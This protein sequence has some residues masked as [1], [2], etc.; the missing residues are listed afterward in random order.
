MVYQGCSS[1][2]VDLASQQRNSVSSKKEWGFEHQTS[3]PR[4]PQSNGLA[5]RAVQTAKGI[6]KKSERDGTDINKALLNM[7]NVPRNQELGS[8]AQRLFSRRTK[9]TL[10]VSAD[11]LKPEIINNVKEKLEALR[12]KQKTYADI[13]AAPA[14]EV[15]EGSKVRVFDSHR[16]WIPGTIVASTPH[17]RSFI[18]KTARGN[19]RRNTSFIR[20]T[21]ANLKDTKTVV[22]TVHQP[23]PTS[24]EERDSPA[25]NGEAD[26]QSTNGHSTTV[27]TGR[28]VKAP[29][30][31]N[32]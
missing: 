6:I 25:A 29:V 23:H 7:R 1:Q 10:P 27:T 31:L 3:S 5:E 16:K 17:P 15:K 21:K 18:V 8:P 4:Y 13:H 28:L 26:A 24:Q 9:T 19:L 30:R 12:K 2:T 11:L 22:P 14:P 20:P 32:L